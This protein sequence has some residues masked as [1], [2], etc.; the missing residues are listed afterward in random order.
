MRKSLFQLSTIFGLLVASAALADESG[1]HHGFV[2]GSSFEDAQKHAVANGFKLAPLSDDLPGSWS[3]AETGQ[4]LF[5]CGDTVTSIT[6]RLNG[7]LEEFT[8]LV[9]SLT[10]KFGEPET[11]ILSVPSGTG[12][13]STIDARFITGDGGALVQ[14]QSID[15]K[16]SFSASFWNE[17]DCR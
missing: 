9:F 4:T 1:M 10:V 3:V 2:L 8:A 11:Q 14:L 15:G 13:I 16:R 7:D 17:S 5:V 12:I 6:E